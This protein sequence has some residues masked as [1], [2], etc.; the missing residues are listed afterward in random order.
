MDI[1]S[2]S[3]LFWTLLAVGS[4]GVGLMSR[5]PVTRY[6]WILIVRTFSFSDGEKF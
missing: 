3:Y 2:Q 6:P 1:A 5:F 4:N